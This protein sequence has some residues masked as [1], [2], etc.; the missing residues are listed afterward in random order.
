MLRGL[1]EVEE[2]DREGKVPGFRKGTAK[3]RKET[4]ITGTYSFRLPCSD[5]E[6]KSD[7]DD[8]DDIAI[9]SNHTILK[10]DLDHHQGI[11]IE[12]MLQPLGLPT[13]PGTSGAWMRTLIT[14]DPQ[15]PIDLRHCSTL[16]K[17]K[18]GSLASLMV[19]VKRKSKSKGST[20][21]DDRLYSGNSI[22]N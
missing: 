1:V 21:R 7:D 19:G 11:G 9:T 8:A 3:T 10:S 4:S 18:L 2:L 14:S 6:S 22:R 20:R 13:C 17:R 5:I 16:P 12:S 15:P